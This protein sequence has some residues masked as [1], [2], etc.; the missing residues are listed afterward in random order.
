MQYNNSNK[1]K[2]KVWKQLVKRAGLPDRSRAVLDL[3]EGTEEAIDSAILMTAQAIFAEIWEN[4]KVIPTESSTA[5]MVTSIE[6]LKIEDR[7]LNDACT[8]CETRKPSVIRRT[9]G[10]RICAGCEKRRWFGKR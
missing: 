2:E 3:E 4:Q 8:F 1:I 10:K 7:W 5:G 6:I 9:D